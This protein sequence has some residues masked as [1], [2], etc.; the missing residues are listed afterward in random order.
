MAT[1]IKR[2]KIDGVTYDLENRSIVLSTATGTLDS[3]QLQTLQSSDN[4]YIIYNDIRYNLYIDD[5]TTR[6]YSNVQA[7]TSTY[8]NITLSTGAYEVGTT[9]ITANM[10]IMSYG[11]STWNDFINAYN[12]N[13]IVY[14]KASS[15]TD[16]ST[17]T[18]GRMAFMAFLNFSG[19][20][21]TSVEFQYYRSVSSH[22][23]SQQ[24]DQVF[25]Y[26]LTNAGAWSVTIR[27]ASSKVAT[28]TGLTS[29]YANGTITLSIDSTVATKSYVDDAI[30]AAIADTY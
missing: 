29:A 21:P 8:I 28:G 25:I 19:T 23:S 22:T 20:T 26:K 30:G 12:S 14:C 6:I 9:N 10:T 27:E 24:G 16:P 11:N 1:A 2:I 15:N 5:G 4:N 7:T 3:E 17:G 13:S 18:Q